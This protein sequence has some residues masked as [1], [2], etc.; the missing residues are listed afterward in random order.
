MN[1]GTKNLL[2][3]FGFVSGTS[4]HWQD[5]DITSENSLNA[6]TTFGAEAVGALVSKK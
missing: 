6:K 3:I 2:N 5:F 1:C 4:D